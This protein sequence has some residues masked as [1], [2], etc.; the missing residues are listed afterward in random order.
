MWAAGA[1]LDLS[2]DRAP[3]MK[4]L[5]KLLFNFVE[6][7]A[8]LVREG[9]LAI[10]A[11]QKL[12]TNWL[13]PLIVWHILF[14]G[15]LQAKSLEASAQTHGAFVGQL[16]QAELRRTHSE[17]MAAI[18]GSGILSASTHVL[19]NLKPTPGRN[20]TFA[21]LRGKHPGLKLTS[22]QD[23]DDLLRQVGIDTADDESRRILSKVVESVHW[24]LHPQRWRSI[25][26][27]TLLSARGAVKDGTKSELLLIDPEQ[28]PLL[29]TAAKSLYKRTFYGEYTFSP[30][31]KNTYI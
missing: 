18:P 25:T 1:F 31:H 6:P 26:A 7:L 15:Y 4:D 16:Q 2:K 27:L 19:A 24:F 14:E 29:V 11:G 10:H 9:A 3:K 21:S 12:C 5:C 22:F 23:I 28:P 8:M 17:V 20:S 30:K 13:V